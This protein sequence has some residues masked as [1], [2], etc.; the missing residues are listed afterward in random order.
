[1]QRSEV[2]ANGFPAG[3]MLME[4]GFD[5]TDAIGS[6]SEHSIQSDSPQLT[7]EQII[8]LSG[9][10]HKLQ[11]DDKAQQVNIKSK[12]FEIEEVLS[13]P[14]A[15]PPKKVQQENKP[16][17]INKVDENANYSTHIEVKKPEPPK[18]HVVLTPPP[19][20]QKHY[21][22]SVKSIQVQM[23]VVIAHVEDSQNI[24]V[25]PSN[26]QE[27]WKNFI[28]VTNKHVKM[29]ECLKKSPEV[30]FIVLA[31]PKIGDSYSRGLVKKLRTQDEIAKVE[32]MEYGF[33]DVVKY[34]DMKCLTE[35][36]VNAPR[37]V[38]KISIRGVPNET[39]NAHEIVRY[40]TSMQENGTELIVKNLDL[41]E[42]T[43][44]CVHFNAVLVDAE[45]FVPVHEHINRLVAVDTPPPDVHMEDIVEPKEKSGQKNNVSYLFNIFLLIDWILKLIFFCQCLGDSNRWLFR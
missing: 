13:A 24:F 22:P 41:I 39:E 44:V 32:F 5:A 12:V 28:D 25:V 14:P 21:H 30:G 34:T 26:E 33:T 38:N 15:T 20:K 19:K 35:E 16:P 42:K 36:L 8:K 43:Q 29:A 27:N 11:I 40:L 2:H 18:S 31:K 17:P 4:P 45:K 7:R 3:R 1:M 10:M 6:V 37:L 23:K 9:T